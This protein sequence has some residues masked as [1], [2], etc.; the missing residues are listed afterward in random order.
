[1]RIQLQDLI[2]AIFQIWQVNEPLV[3][4]DCFLAHTL[5]TQSDLNNHCIWCWWESVVV[6]HS[7]NKSCRLRGSSTWRWHECCRLVPHQRDAISDGKHYLFKFRVVTHPLVELSNCIAKA[8]AL[9]LSI[10]MAVDVWVA[11]VKNV[12]TDDHASGR[13]KLT[14]QDHLNI[15]LVLGLVGIHKDHVKFTCHNLQR[16]K[17]WTNNNFMALG[18]IWKGGQARR[19]PLLQVWIDVERHNL[20]R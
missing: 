8:A 15:S 13:E 9:W 14:L 7:R 18:C 12:V 11:V 5:F 19:N 4:D 20:C 17:C 1:M 3:A 6:S 2:T 16:I 10:E